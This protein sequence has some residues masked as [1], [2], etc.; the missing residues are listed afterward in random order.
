MF[1]QSRLVYW[2]ESVEILM[3][4]VEDW[5]IRQAKKWCAFMQNPIYT[6]MWGGGADWLMIVSRCNKAA[7]DRR[8]CT[9]REEQHS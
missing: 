5:F 9:G 2:N 7:V 6:K 8:A 3:C 4:S 1:L